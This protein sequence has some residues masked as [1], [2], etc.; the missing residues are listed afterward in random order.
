MAVMMMMVV[1]MVMV[2]MMM[3]MMMM[4][5]M[6]TMM[7]MMMMMMMMM[8]TMAGGYRD[9][10]YS[11]WHFRHNYFPTGFA[12]ADEYIRTLWANSSHSHDIMAWDDGTWRISA[13]QREGW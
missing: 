11:Y 5:T 2:M 6:M 4:M 10:P 7:T 13:D 12:V 1:V 9:L 8:M 3:M